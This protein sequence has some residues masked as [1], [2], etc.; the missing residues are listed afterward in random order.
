M[1]SQILTLKLP[2]ALYTRLRERALQANRTVEDEMLDVLATAVP[3]A[4]ELP[5]DLAE[6]ISPLA[7]LDNQAL[8]RAAHSHFAPEAAA[9]L[10][11]LHI[12]RQRVG[13]NE[14]EGQSLAGLVRQ[15]E[16]AMLVRA[17]AASLLNRRGLSVPDPTAAQ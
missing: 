9:R 2:D 11:E 14:A 13:L 16:R 17:E 4:G 5:A 1:T 12:K 15:Y 10:E 3:L 7:L 6:A 8:L